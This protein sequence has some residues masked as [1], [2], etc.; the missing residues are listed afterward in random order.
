MVKHTFYST[1]ISDKTCV[2][3]PEESFHLT[4][5]LRLG[6]ANPVRI[7]DGKGNIFEG[8][9]GKAHVGMSEIEDLKI[10]EKQKPKSYHLHIAIAP[11]KNN[12]RFE[13][14]LEKVTEIGVD[15]IS[16]LK[17]TRSEKSN[18]RIDRA[19]KI[20]TAA[21][22]Q[23]LN[24]F[25]PVMHS[26]VSFSDFIRDNRP[27]IGLIA[28][29]MEGN[30]MIITDIPDEQKNI[31]IMIG[32]EGDFTGEELTLALDNGYI[33]VSLGKSRLRSETAGMVACA[34]VACKFGLT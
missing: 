13:W 4:R 7:I 14:F 18:F 22:K 9:V 31:T 26:L 27:G 6:V 1:E 15:E 32:P 21:M 10:F 29:C 24:A 3:S 19:E 17:A 25:R 11:P 12:E 30:K 2:L 33:P 28:H 20:I 16:I 34:Q 5:V 8:R 23:S